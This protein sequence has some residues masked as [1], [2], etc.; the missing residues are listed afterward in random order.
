MR[1]SVIVRTSPIIATVA[2]ITGCGASTS[3]AG[4]ATSVTDVTL[5]EWAI[6]SVPASVPAGRVT[7]QVANDGPDDRHE[8]V[9][10]RTDLPLDALPTKPGGSVDEA[11]DGVEVA[12]EVEGIDPGGSGTVTLDLAPGKYVLI[13]NLIEDIRFHYELGMRSPFEVTS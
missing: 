2:L 11:G 12:G 1:R 7:F 13:C 3:P 10:V 9:V 6:A 4:S 5:K 8:L